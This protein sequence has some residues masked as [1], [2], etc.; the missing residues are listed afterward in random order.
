MNIPK[1]RLW[2][3]VAAFGKDTV[4]PIP[5]K[6]S[7]QIGRQSDRRGGMHLAGFELCSPTADALCLISIEYGTSM[8]RI[9]MHTAGMRVFAGLGRNGVQ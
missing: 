2:C 3:I 8:H 6:Q 1:I 7:I 4:C 5:A 9:D